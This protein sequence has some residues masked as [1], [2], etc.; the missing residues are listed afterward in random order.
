MAKHWQ[1]AKN[2][3]DYRAGGEQVSLVTLE[4]AEAL[5][6]ADFDKVLIGA[7]IRYGKA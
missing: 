6:L 2:E 7:S 5:S 4:Q 1:F 3:D